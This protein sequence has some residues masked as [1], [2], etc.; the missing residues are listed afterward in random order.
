MKIAR[1]L[2]PRHPWETVTEGTAA[3]HSNGVMCCT[4]NGP[5]K[6]EGKPANQ[7]TRKNV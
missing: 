3:G 7:M 4:L 2:L 1:W 5:V 6:G